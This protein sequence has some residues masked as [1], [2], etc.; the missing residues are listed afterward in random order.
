[1]LGLHLGGNMK[2]GYIVLGVC[3]FVSVGMH[4]VQYHANE[5]LQNDVNLYEESQV[6][7]YDKIESLEMILSAEQKAEKKLENWYVQEI[8]ELSLMA[9]AGNGDD[10]FQSDYFAATGAIAQLNGRAINANSGV[11]FL[12][13]YDKHIAKVSIEGYMPVW[14]LTQEEYSTS[15]QEE[16]GKA[17]F[18]IGSGCPNFFDRGRPHWRN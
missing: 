4:V 15:F 11:T 10:V 18:G 8:P 17:A 1:M 9:K 5:T 16:D 13:L 12:E 2:K 7:L 3:L 6:L 14:Y